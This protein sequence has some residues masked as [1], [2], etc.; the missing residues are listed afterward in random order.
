MV[1]K[2]SIF[3]KKRKNQ[4]VQ[5]CEECWLGRWRQKR[6]KVHMCEIPS[7]LKV[8]IIFFEDRMGSS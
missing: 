1:W 6:K 5:F 2:Q 4:S 3:G 7:P 8:G